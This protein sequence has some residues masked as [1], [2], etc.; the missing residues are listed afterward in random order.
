MVSPCIHRPVYEYESG[1]ISPTPSH[2]LPCFT[3]ELSLLLF[4]LLIAAI[5]MRNDDVVV[6]QSKLI[7][8]INFRSETEQQSWTFSKDR[9][10]NPTEM[11]E[12]KKAWLWL[13][14]HYLWKHIVS[15]LGPLIWL[16]MPYFSFHGHFSQPNVPPFHSQQ[17]QVL[18]HPPLLEWKAASQSYFLPFEVRYI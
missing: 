12:G 13:T 4:K 17:K 15:L 5:M 1:Y 11:G 3:W 7:I 2:P 9:G 8:H 16:S 6:L 14:H 10:G 18:C